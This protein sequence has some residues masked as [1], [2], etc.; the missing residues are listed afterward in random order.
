MI[1][2]KEQKCEPENKN[3]ILKST[4]KNCCVCGIPEKEATEKGLKFIGMNTIYNKKMDEFLGINLSESQEIK[5]V[6]V[7]SKCI[8]N[9]T[10]MAEK[11]IANKNKN[12]KIDLTEKIDSF[13]DYIL[14]SSY[15][16][17]LDNV[18]T[19]QACFNMFDAT[20]ECILKTN[21]KLANYILKTSIIELERKQQEFNNISTCK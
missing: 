7:C 6:Y 19:A 1:E 15:L 5:D 13:T 8:D 18:I 3:S 11:I 17:N 20:L 21:P 12:D 4:E 14:S 2:N 9:A 16:F 10:V